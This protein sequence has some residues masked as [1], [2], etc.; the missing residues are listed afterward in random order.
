MRKD[1]AVALR[2]PA[3]AEGPMTR[4]RHQL[5]AL[6]LVTT[7]IVSWSLINQASAATA[8]DLDRD[9]QRDAFPVQP[10]R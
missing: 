1:R 7:S 10:S 2:L 3:L 4:I 9:A 5:L 6:I 8:Q